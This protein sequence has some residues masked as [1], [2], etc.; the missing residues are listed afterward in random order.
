MPGKAPL[1]RDYLT[2]IHTFL[3]ILADLSNVAMVTNGI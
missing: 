3:F 1:H 2:M